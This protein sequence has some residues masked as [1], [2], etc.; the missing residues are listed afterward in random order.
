MCVF[1]IVLKCCWPLKLE[2][3]SARL[4]AWQLF[5]VHPERSGVGGGTCD[6]VSSPFAVPPPWK[7]IDRQGVQVRW[8]IYDNGAWWHHAIKALGGVTQRL[9]RRV[10]AFVFAMH[11]YRRG[12]EGHWLTS[13]LCDGWR[14]LAASFVFLSIFLS[15]SLPVS[16]RFYLFCSRTWLTARFRQERPCQGALMTPLCPSKWQLIKCF[17]PTSFQLFVI[18]NE[19]FDQ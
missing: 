14:R 4:C 3:E 9:P 2:R 13:L 18:I 12:R 19:L 10:R 7:F 5:P 6:R 17:F 8:F 16:H 15:T 11:E 1:K